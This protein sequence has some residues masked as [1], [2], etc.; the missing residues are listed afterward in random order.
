MS[1]YVPWMLDDV[2]SDEDLEKPALGRPKIKNY[3][4]HKKL[5]KQFGPPDITGIVKAQLK[6][7]MG[8]MIIS[9]MTHRLFK[10][11]LTVLVCSSNVMADQVRRE[12]KTNMSA[13]VR[14][15]ELDYQPPPLDTNVELDMDFSCKGMP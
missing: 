5:D 3:G 9:G 2:D 8:K 7:K 13:D 14:F 6:E 1:L 10:K 12:V 15:V 4:A 11:Y